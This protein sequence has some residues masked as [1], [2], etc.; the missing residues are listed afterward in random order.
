[1]CLS[2][3]FFLTDD[4]SRGHISFMTHI[5]D[6]VERAGGP[7][8]LA[9]LLGFKSHTSILRWAKVPERRIVAVE[10]VTGIPREQLRPDLFER[11]PTEARP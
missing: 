11:T 9:R 3:T 2:V 7:A 5:R 10:R 6:I 1:M 4:V 8:K